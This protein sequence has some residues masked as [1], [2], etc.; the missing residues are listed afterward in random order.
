VVE[1]IGSGVC[2]SDTAVQMITIETMGLNAN[3]ITN[4]QVAFFP[5]GKLEITSLPDNFQIE[6]LQFLTTDGKVIPFTFNQ[7]TND[8]IA[9]NFNFN[10][11]FII[12]YLHH[13]NPVYF[14]RMFKS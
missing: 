2:G 12:S 6:S 7:I 4:F 14:R 1:L 5:T 10:G 11:L 9:I 13:E 8:K 3:E